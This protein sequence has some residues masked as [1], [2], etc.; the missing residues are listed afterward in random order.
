MYERDE[1]GGVWCVSCRPIADEPCRVSYCEDGAAEQD[2]A[3]RERVANPVVGCWACERELPTTDVPTGD[4]GLCST[5]WNW[6]VIRWL[7]TADDPPCAA[8]LLSD[9]RQDAPD[10]E[11]AGTVESV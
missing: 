10:S 1:R 8:H 2:A 11:I 6:W 5:H 7:A 9:G 3:R 4:I